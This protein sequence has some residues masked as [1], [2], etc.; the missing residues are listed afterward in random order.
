M[1]DFMEKVKG[2]FRKVGAAL[3]K[4]WNVAGVPVINA[5]KKGFGFIKK[6][7]V[8]GLAWLHEKTHTKKFKH[9]MDKCTTGILIFLMCSPVLILGYI[10][11][12]F[13]FNIS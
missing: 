10:F 5:I 2:F 7:W 9:I 4:A 1:K 3:K 11:I 12:W 8:L 6:Y 13:Y